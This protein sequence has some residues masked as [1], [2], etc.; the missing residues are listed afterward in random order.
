MIPPLI[1]YHPYRNR[2][3][4]GIVKAFLKGLKKHRQPFTII[5]KYDF[6][7]DQI[8]PEAVV[9]TGR[10]SSSNVILQTCLSK[11]ARFVYFDKGYIHRG[12]GVK[13]LGGYI[14]FSV[15]GLHPLSH[16]QQIPRPPDRWNRLKVPMKPLRRSG[17][18]IIFAGC[19]DK[20][21]RL[22]D[23]DPVEYAKNII[24]GIKKRTGRQVFYRP[25]P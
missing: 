25:K 10:L 6:N 8:D 17:S 21:A 4:Q 22:Y 5:S 13:N 18:H 24:E 9:V 2:G 16:F 11:G 3:E 19:S 20:L 12:W 23:F 15:N 1:V 7:P 14:R